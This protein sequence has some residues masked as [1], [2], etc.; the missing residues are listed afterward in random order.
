MNMVTP[1]PFLGVALHGVGAIFAATCY[2]PQKKVN[3][4]SWQTYWLT[5]AVFC[6]FLLPILGAWLTIPELGAVLREA[7][8][9]N[10]NVSAD[11]RNLAHVLPRVIREVPLYIVAHSAWIFGW[12][13]QVGRC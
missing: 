7:P 12:F 11:V 5:Q 13:F 3:G 8:R 6:W 2:T 9:T 4:W 1:N 10:N